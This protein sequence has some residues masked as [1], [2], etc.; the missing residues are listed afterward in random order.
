MAKV[1]RNFFHP[2][3]VASP[4]EDAGPDA[5]T[6]HPAPSNLHVYCFTVYHR[7]IREAISYQELKA[8]DE[9]AKEAAAAT[10]D[11]PDEGRWGRISSAR[12]RG[13]FRDLLGR[14]SLRLVSVVR[15]ILSAIRFGVNLS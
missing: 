15:D 2:A 6:T 10:G 4:E 3:R 7:E 13:A 12:M 9:G 14:R 11:S 5:R 8:K 1:S